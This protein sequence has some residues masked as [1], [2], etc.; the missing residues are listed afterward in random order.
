MAKSFFL[1][2]CITC[3]NATPLW[4]HLESRKVIVGPDARYCVMMAFR[5]KL[6]LVVDFKIS[7][8]IKE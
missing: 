1:N 5:S 8:L 3:A 7:I 2:K 6:L 4:F